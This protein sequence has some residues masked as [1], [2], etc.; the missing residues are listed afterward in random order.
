[1]GKLKVGMVENE[2]ERGCGWWGVDRTGG[3][4]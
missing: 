3:R 2:A 1:M 4:R